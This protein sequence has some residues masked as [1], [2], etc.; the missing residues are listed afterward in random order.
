[1]RLDPDLQVTHLK[2]WTLTSVIDTDIRCRAIPWGRMILES[3]QAPD[4]LNLRLSQRVAA[5]LAPLALLAA[6]TAPIAL[7][8]AQWLLL[9][10]SALVLGAAAALNAGLLGCFARCRGWAFA[11]G[12]GLFHQVHL[13]YS[14]TTFAVL[15]LQRW[16]APRLRS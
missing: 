16:L 12:A 3:G 11:L 15:A 9:L 4:D 10:S 14:A 8:T 13:T 6:L 5:G 7:V 1:M 2:R